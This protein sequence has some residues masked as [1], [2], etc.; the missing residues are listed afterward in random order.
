MN[1]R[2]CAVKIWRLMDSSAFIA[3]W[4]CGKNCYHIF[5]NSNDKCFNKQFRKG[6]CPHDSN[7]LDAFK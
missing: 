6:L 1:Q 7:A 3:K 5:V 4:Y 2:K